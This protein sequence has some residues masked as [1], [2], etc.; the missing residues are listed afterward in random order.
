MAIAFADIGELKIK[1]RT[2]RDVTQGEDAS[3]IRT[4]PLPQ[5]FAIARNFTLNLYR[6]QMFENMAQARA[7][8]F[9]WVRHTQATF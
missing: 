2:V 3:R 9:I 1:S 7:F 4:K 8:M 6:N 5:I